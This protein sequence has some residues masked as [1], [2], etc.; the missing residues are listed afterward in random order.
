M[1]A[2]CSDDV[3]QFV[4]EASIVD[5]DGG[6]PVAGTDADTLRIEISEGDL[7]VR[8]LEYPISDGQFDATLEFA[9]FSSLT[10]VRVS[11]A[12]PSTEQITA[13]PAFVPAATEGFL[14]LVAANPSSCTPVSFNVMEAGRASFG[15][16]QSGTFALVVGGTEPTEEQI[17]FFDALEWA[18]RLFT[19]DFSLSYL[20]ETRAATVGEG[21]ILV[22]P[23]DATP[24]IFDMLNVDNRITQV[25]LHAGAGPQSALVSVPGV[26]AMVIG[27]E[28][29][30]AARAGVS[31]VALDGVVTSRELSEP[32]AGPTAAVLGEDVLVVGGNTEG[33]AELLLAGGG[34]GQPIDGVMD[35]VR[36]GALL[37]GDAESRAL[38]IGGAD[39]RDAIRQDTL[40]FDGCPGACVP[41]AGPSWDTARLRAT[42]PE[43]SA[44]VIGGQGS[45]GVE[46]V[47]WSGNAV[48]IEPVL[49]LSSPRAGAG[50]VVYESGA[51]VVAG[52]DD[53]VSARDDFE[54]C[55]PAALTQL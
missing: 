18:S 14:R 8:E 23:A 12:G 41:S 32:R 35:G 26:G 49:E 16:V 37:V 22:L 53:G 7:R 55:V 11:M 52:G 9:S 42:L 54:F 45:Q 44:L 21:Q 5:G 24:F 31:L 3:S 48:T 4:F 43:Y 29:G 36:K 6:N 38:L 51:F 30:G 28:L 50:A 47:R 33:N 27:G 15:M 10:R 34:V 2:A 13:P 1:G 40:R 39:E 25:N 46:E 19:A 20:G 17:E